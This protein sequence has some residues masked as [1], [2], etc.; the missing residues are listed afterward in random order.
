VVAGD[1]RRELGASRAV[2]LINKMLQ[3]LDRRNALGS[4]G[5][6]VPPQ[7]VR[8]VSAPGAGREWF[9]R[10]LALLALIAIGWVG[11]VAYQVRPRPLAT[12]LAFNADEEARRK[13]AATPAMKIA[14]P[15][16]PVPEPVVQV[17]AP[18]PAPIAATKQAAAPRAEVQPN[19]PP[20]EL[21]KLALSIDRPIAERVAKPPARSPVVQKLV[22]ADAGA[23]RVSKRE[24]PRSP[25]EE[26]EALFRHGV[27]FLNQGRVSEA[28]RNFAAALAKHSG[29]EAARQALIAILIERRQLDDAGRLLEEGLSLNPAQM[30][31]AAVLARVLVERGDYREAANVLG[32][33]RNAGADDGEYQLLYGAV[34]QRLGR[35]VEAVEAFERAA[36]TDNQPGVIWVALGI[37]LE[38]VGKRDGALQAY[39]RSLVAGPVAQ[40]ALAYAESRI[41]ALE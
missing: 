9:W 19:P 38:A 13:A 14:P 12:E 6:P 5:G 8:V 39:R 18:A 27:V 17:N 23:S 20:P 41:R 2:S 24:I 29:H 22:A 35:H 11:W 33:T 31:F 36:R 4:A 10:T 1:A 3:E 28:Q 25:S 37:S 32:A 40:D 16:Q 30:T 7:H 34:L 15:A 21:F 26:A